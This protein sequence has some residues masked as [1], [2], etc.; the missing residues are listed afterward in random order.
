ME[1]CGIINI[2][3]GFLLSPRREG[4][5]KTL[6]TY[7]IIYIIPGF[8]LSQCFFTW[9]PGVSFVWMTSD[10]GLHQA[11]LEVLDDQHVVLLVFTDSLC[12]KIH[13]KTPKINFLLRSRGRDSH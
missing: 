13:Y 1:T 8:M 6:E 12:Q 3:L 11:C 2:I 7:G 5:G 4:D 9:G 10:I